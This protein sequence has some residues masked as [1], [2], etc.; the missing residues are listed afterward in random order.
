MPTRPFHTLFCAALLGS[1]L[2]VAC[3]RSRAAPTLQV[4]TNVW[5]G[6]EPLYL[7][8]QHPETILKLREV[9]FDA[10]DHLKQMPRDAHARM[11]PRGHSF[12]RAPPC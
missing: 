8:R 7:A 9:W 12:P 6:Y 1:C 4:A 2:A 10:L 5:L 11:A 3:G